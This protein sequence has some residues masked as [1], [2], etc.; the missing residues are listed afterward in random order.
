MFTFW[1]CKNCGS[2]AWRWLP[3]LPSIAITYYVNGFNIT[4][5]WALRIGRNIN[6]LVINDCFHFVCA[7]SQAKKSECLDTIGIGFH[8][9]KRMVCEH[10][11]NRQMAIGRKAHQTENVSFSFYF[12]CVCMCVYGHSLNKRHI[13]T[14]ITNAQ[15]AFLCKQKSMNDNFICTH[16]AVIRSSPRI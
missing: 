6:N 15:T 7:H 13:E 8:V 2:I 1:R 9:N 12:V 10:V 14:F 11:I 16:L 5:K 4:L 3:T